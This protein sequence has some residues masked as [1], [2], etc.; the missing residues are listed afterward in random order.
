L[1][2]GEVEERPAREAR[3]RNVFERSRAAQ[4]RAVGLRECAK[5]RATV[6][7]PVG[8]TAR[9]FHLAFALNLFEVPDVLSS[10]G[11]P[12]DRNPDN[13]LGIEGVRVTAPTSSPTL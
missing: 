12:A 6:G 10:A 2:S 8:T 5:S 11:A 13:A 4:K 9:G 7:F 3:D 1:A